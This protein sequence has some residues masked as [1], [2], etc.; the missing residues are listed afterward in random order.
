MNDALLFHDSEVRLAFAD[1][2]TLRVQF[3]AAHVERREAGPRAGAPVLGYAR[4]LELAFARAA[5]T[6]ALHECVGRLVQGRLSAAGAAHARLPLPFDAP[7][8]VRCELA[9]HNGTL[10]EVEAGAVSCRFTGDP[11]FVESYAC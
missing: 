3:S 5:W 6:G 7:G 1:G 9:F 4:T 2:D 11:R 8:P 10:L